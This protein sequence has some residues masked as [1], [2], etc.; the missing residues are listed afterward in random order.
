MPYSVPLVI[1]QNISPSVLAFCQSVSVKFLGRGLKEAP[2]APSPLPSLPW[3]VRQI[4][5]PIKISLPASRV[6]GFAGTKF[7]SPFASANLSAG[8]LGFNPSS[9]EEY[10]EVTK[11]KGNNITPI[12][13]KTL[14]RLFTLHLLS[15][16][17]FLV[18]IIVI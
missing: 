6:F 15:Y 17:I 9:S 4:P 10:T 11:D 5:F 1:A 3:Q 18:L 16:H 8:T 13:N 12:H 14:F 2:P 7:G